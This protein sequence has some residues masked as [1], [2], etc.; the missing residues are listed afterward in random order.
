VFLLVLVV[1][2]L[3]WLV[4]I[5]I[6]RTADQFKV[7]VFNAGELLLSKELANGETMHVELE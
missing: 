2:G 7:L 5:R 4:D 3:G 1:G 6:T